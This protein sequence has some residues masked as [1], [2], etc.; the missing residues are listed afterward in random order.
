MVFKGFEKLYG[1]GQMVNLVYEIK[2]KIKDEFGLTVN[3]GVSTNFILS[4]MAGDFSRPN[5]VHTLFP[6]EIERKTLV[7]NAKSETEKGKPMFRYDYEP[8]RCLIPACKFY[9]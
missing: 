6:A 2:D 9:E 5:K 1:R 4:K 8:H 7:F 3:I